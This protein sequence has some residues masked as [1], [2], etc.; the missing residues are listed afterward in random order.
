MKTA[1][2]VLLLLLAACARNRQ[3]AARSEDAASTAELRGPPLTPTASPSARCRREPDAHAASSADG[4]LVVYVVTDRTRTDSTTVID[5]P[6][7]DLCIARAGEAPRLLL[8]GHG[9]AEDAGVEETL[10]DFDNLL[11]SPDQKTLY[12]TTAGWVTSSAAHAVDLA[13]GKERFLVD[14][15]IAAVLEH[16]PY[17]GMLLA[18]HYRLDDKYPVSSPHYRGRMEM[19]SVVTPAGKTVRSLPEDEAARKKVVDGR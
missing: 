10:A 13:T 8:A 17:K 7:Q 4:T 5:A 6:H 9:A 11:L 2:A 15:G 3:S 14:G 19:W 16:G 12:F 1:L 18:T